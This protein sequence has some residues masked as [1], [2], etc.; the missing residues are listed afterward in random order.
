MIQPQSVGV[1]APQ[2]AHFAE[3]LPLRSGGTLPEYELVY[4]TY[5]EL[6]ADRSNAVLVCH[7]LSGSHHVAGHYADDA[8]NVGWWDNVVGPG[9][10]L[11]TRKFFVIGVNNLGG[12][13][14]STGPMSI[15]PATGQ[16]WGAD[17][18]FVTV[19]D[20][21]E[22]QA[23]LADRLGIRRF[24][25]VMGGSLGGMQAL[26]WTLQ[27]PERVANAVVIAS[28]PKLTAQNIA[29]NE[30]ARQAILSDPDFHGGHYYAHGV[31]PTR[32]LKL[33]RM[34]GHITYLSDDAMGDKFGRSLRHGKAIYSYDV[35]FEIESYLR[36]Q[37]DKF[38]GFFDANTYLLATKALDYF[39]PAF[40]HGGNLPA[41]LSR[42]TADFLVVSFSTDWRFSPARS[43][44]IVYALLHNQ[45]N[46]SY[47]QIESDAGH[48]SFLLDEAQYHALL[49]AYFDRIKV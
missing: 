40:E 25:A 48:D 38:A 2:R 19:E 47:A 15:N 22:A 27:Y 30:V 29:F 24:A 4:E 10:P 28:A 8:K 49:T 33:A 16:P 44:E 42:A 32:G 23:R 35:E 41:A 12:C 45:R 43:R 26:S 13:H 31:V 6:N 7:A 5:G 21:V 18:P 11:D 3:P 17:F 34:V 36:Y 1:V 20:W 9:K 46:V 37:G 14:G 39:D